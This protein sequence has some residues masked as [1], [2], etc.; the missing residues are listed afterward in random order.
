MQT[1]IYSCFEEVLSKAESLGWEDS[2]IDGTDDDYDPDT[3]D[4]VEEE[5][6]TY[7]KDQGFELVM[8]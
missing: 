3:G 7:I 8:L 2:Y 4:A 6:L 1:F 5:C